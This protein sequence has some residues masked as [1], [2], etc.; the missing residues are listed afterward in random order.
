MLTEN[1]KA[2]VITRM[3]ALIPEATDSDQLLAQLVDDA[4]AFVCSYT[5]RREV[6]SQ[7]DR[8]VGDL[9]IIEYNRRGTEG[10]QSRSEGGESYSFEKAP[11]RV[12][13]VL[14]KYRLARVGG[15]FYETV[16][17]EEGSA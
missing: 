1:R 7:L 13:D 16:P 5:N 4:A 6:P 11:A 12:Y 14:N 8:T 2:A 3:K 10:E 15:K 9:A 17:D